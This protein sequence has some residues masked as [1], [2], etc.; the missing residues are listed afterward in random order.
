MLRAAPLERR[1]AIIDAI[2]D[3]EIELCY[4]GTDDQVANISTSQ[5]AY[6]TFARHR[7]TILGRDSA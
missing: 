7:A 2:D 5:R 1:W 4:C 6:V 3:R